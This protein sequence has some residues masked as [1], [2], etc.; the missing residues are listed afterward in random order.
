MIK[1]ILTIGVLVS[2]PIWAQPP[3]GAAPPKPTAP[4]ARRAAP[5]DPEGYWVAQITEDWH[6]RI[7]A[8]AKGDVGGIPVNAQGRRAA[9]AWDP[10]KDAAAGEACKAYGVGGILRMPGRIHITWEGDNALKME[11]DSGS[12]TRMLSFGQGSGQ[13]GDW[14]GVAVASWDRQAPALSGFTLGNAGGGAPSLKI[15][16]TKAKPGYLA[17]NG[18]PYGANATFTEYYDVF[19]VPG[20]DTL[21]VV[22]VEVT[23]PENLSTPYWY[24]VHFKKQAD[25]TGWSP[26]P[27]SA[28]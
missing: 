1:S 16:T 12:Q 26:K 23:D 17:R 25:A 27:C 10:E 11:T 5:F 14:Q 7:K 9:A 28:K 8:A 19:Q 15:V 18:V 24:S 13:G 21:L 6:Y 4:N 22:T 2:A 3:G 20:G